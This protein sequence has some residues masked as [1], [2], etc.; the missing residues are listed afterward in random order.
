MTPESFISRWNR[1]GA[2]ERANYGIFLTELCTLLDVPQPDPAQD[3]DAENAYVF[4]RNVTFSEADG[5]HSIGRI[6]LYRRASF[7]L[8]AKQGSDADTAEDDEA[9][10][11]QAATAKKPKRRGTAIRGTKAWDDAMVRARG[12]ADRYA[13]ALP[14]SEGWPPFL[15][16]VDVGHSIELYSDFSRSGKTYVQFPDPQSFRLTLDDLKREDVRLRLR[17][18]W[19]DPLA[20]DPSRRAAKVTRELAE[21]LAELAKLLEKAKHDAEDVAKFL[22]RCLFTMFAEDVEL[23]PRGS[24][25]NLLAD[26][27]DE[28]EN[29]KPAAEDLWRTMNTGGYSAGLRKSLLRFNGG[30]F[31]ESEALP[32]TKPMLALLHEAAGSDWTDVEP[33]IFG[34]LLERALDPIDRHKLGA[35][36]TPR[37][38]VERLVLP[39]VIEPL[40]EDWQAAYAVAVSA[41]KLGDLAAAQKTVRTFHEQLCKTRVLDP[42]CGSGNFLYVTLEQMKRLEGE[43]LNALVEFG[44]K[45]GTLFEVD[46]HQF[47]GIEVNPRAAAIADLV[48][49]IG[50]LQWHFRTRGHTAPAEPIIKNYKNIECRDAVLAWDRKEAV[51]DEKQ[52]P[53]TRWNGRTMKIHP[54]TGE[55]V[56]DES[57]YV[58]VERYINPRKAEWPAAEFVVGNPPYIGVRKLNSTTGPDYVDAVVSSYPDVKETADFVMYWWHHCAALVEDNLLRRFGL[59]TTNSITQ[60]YSRPVLDFH[61]S[62]VP[63][64]KIV[65]AVD[66]HP[67][68]EDQDGASVQVAMTVVASAAHYQGPLR[69]G[70]VKPQSSPLVEVEYSTVAR[71]TSLLRSDLDITQLKPL[72]SNI[73]FCFQGVIP[74]NSGFKLDSKSMAEMSISTAKLPRIVRRYVIGKDLVQR[75]TPKWVMDCF[76]LSAEEVKSEFP[77]IFQRL[78]DRVKPER[79]QNPRE[80]RRRNWWLFAENAP[81]LRSAIQGLSRYIATPNTAKHRPFMF[82]AP[83]VLPDAM[84]YAIASDDAQI[85]GIL[86]SKPHQIWSRQTGGTLEDRPR[87]NSKVTFLPFPF[88]SGSDEQ[89]E[90]IRELGEQLDA[91]RKRQQSLHPKLTLTEMYNVLDKL[92][93]GETLTPKEKATHEQGLVSVLK[94]IHDDLDAAVFD[95]YGWPATLT[96]EGILERLVALNAE[97]AAEEDEGKIRW[98][99]PEFQNPTDGRAKQKGLALVDDDS[100]D[101]EADEAEKPKKRGKGAKKKPAEVKAKPAAKTAKRDWPKTRE[102]QAKA[103]AAI[104]RDCES[105]VTPDELAR[106]F[107]RAQRDTIEELLQAMVTLGLARKLRGGKFAS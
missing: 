62:R 53:V 25:K 23:I 50:Y 82:L 74:G 21:R 101:D 100:D 40:R 76:G 47:L 88:P 97:R 57:A 43:V 68:V 77:Q 17:Q 37:A 45:Q 30:L 107:T 1:S 51:L 27:R 56:P 78:F 92:R 38:Y 9:E 105:S 13:R 28:P 91:H 79:D 34:T 10:A 3:D 20:L 90:T 35:H 14:V 55:E 11:L 18:I 95:A 71:I 42:A 104:L 32:L 98:L 36:Y 83:D 94:Q 6:D 75:I 48:L 66:D 89:R 7:V 80:I 86:S 65:L 46:P 61:L 69:L 64:V 106:R 60:Q 81:K 49:W 84:A 41:A 72:E 22:M 33:A 39:T 29:F 2:A 26:L 102:A 87:Y 58:L 63:G 99:R 67:W 70:T 96:D 24:F 31:A 103:V 19:L 93:N 44:D 8:E 16:V 15:I 52:Q 5:S 12:Q 4:E 54:V 73:D 85:L 59:I